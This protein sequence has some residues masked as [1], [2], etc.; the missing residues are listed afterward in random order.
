MDFLSAYTNLELAGAGML[1]LSG[2]LLW[3]NVRIWLR[4]SESV[5][6]PT[7]P[8]QVVT[9]LDYTTSGTLIFS[10]TFTVNGRNYEG[11]KPFFAN[12]FRK[13]GREK[14][15]ALLANYP[16]GTAVTV[17]YHPENPALSILEPGRTEGVVSAMVVLVMLVALGVIMLYNPTIISSLMG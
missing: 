15:T 14:T 13:L 1:L 4:A 9:G 10:Y 17:S 7:V 11:K 12:S 2:L 8:G 16:A 3:S 5:R 6:W